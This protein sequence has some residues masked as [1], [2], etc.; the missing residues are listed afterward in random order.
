MS[1]DMRRTAIARIEV[2]RVEQANTS[3]VYQGLR[4]AL[5]DPKTY[6]FVYTSSSLSNINPNNPTDV[7]EYLHDLILWF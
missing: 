4:L 2:D 7:H 6:I 1:A 5:A 3:T